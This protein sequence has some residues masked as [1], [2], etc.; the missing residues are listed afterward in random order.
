MRDLQLVL[1]LIGLF[2]VLSWIDD[3]F[4]R[5]LLAHHL[6]RFGPE[7]HTFKQKCASDTKGQ[8]DDQSRDKSLVPASYENCN[9]SNGHYDTDEEKDGSY[10]IRLWFPCFRHILSPLFCRVIDGCLG[11]TLGR[12]MVPR[13]DETLSQRKTNINHYRGEPAIARLEAPRSE[14]DEPLP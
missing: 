5:W 2:L 10:P 14:G 11:K 13:T 3:L 12:F 1:N 6:M 7:S 9:E 8:T 4:F